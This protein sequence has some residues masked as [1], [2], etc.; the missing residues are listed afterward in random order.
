MRWRKR[1]AFCR[2]VPRGYL[3]EHLRMVNRRGRTIADLHVE[4][5][6]SMVQDRFV[7]IPRGDIAAAIFEACTSVEAHFG[8]SITAM[9]ERPGEAVIRTSLGRQEAYDLV[10]GADG[11]HSKVPKS[12]SALPRNL[13]NA[14]A[15]MSPLSHCPVMRRGGTRLREPHRSQ[16]PGGPRGPAE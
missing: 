2:R 7:S 9:E 16:A 3:I 12:P 11:L 13:K 15:I 6:R 10:I 1:W 4:S 8:E 5:L 14:S